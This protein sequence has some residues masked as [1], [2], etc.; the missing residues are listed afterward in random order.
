MIINQQG[1]GGANYFDQI[2]NEPFIQAFAS[3]GSVTTSSAEYNLFNKTINPASPLNGISQSGNKNFNA[4]IS[5]QI[6]SCRIRN[7]GT[8]AYLAQATPS[9]FIA[10][11]NLAIPYDI[12]SASYI[13]QINISGTVGDIR[14]FDISADGTKMIVLGTASANTIYE[15]SLGTAWQISSASYQSRSFSLNS[16][17]TSM[18]DI[19]LSVSGLNLIALGI[20]NNRLYQ[21]TLGSAWNLSSVTYNTQLSMSSYLTT[22]TSSNIRG[23]GRSDDG[24]SLVVAYTGTGGGNDYLQEIKLSADGTLS[25]ATIG[26]IERLGIANLICFSIS[27]NYSYFVGGSVS[28]AIVYS[29]LKSNKTGI[30]V[31]SVTFGFTNTGIA[32]RLWFYGFRSVANGVQSKPMDDTIGYL[33]K[34]LFAVGSYESSPVTIPLDLYASGSLNINAILQSFDGAYSNLKYSV[35]YKMV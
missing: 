12:N 26:L 15:Y 31:D 25:G 20:N 24:L 9:D 18:R 22:P 29:I 7:N 1:G 21:Y 30:L 32:Q 14:D 4:Q 17:D 19:C 3:I 23:F 16:E 28:L 2:K 10:E 11:Y 6:E 13:G 8:K 27:G 5:G 33:L 34:Q 35:N